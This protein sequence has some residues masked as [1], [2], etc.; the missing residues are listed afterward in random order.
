MAIKSAGKN[1]VLAL[2]ERSGEVTVRI[3]GIML[4]RR[5]CELRICRYFAL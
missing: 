5:R 4:L 1:T 3:G 2:L